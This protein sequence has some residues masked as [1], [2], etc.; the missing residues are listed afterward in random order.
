[1]WVSWRASVGVSSISEIR[2]GLE[3]SQA[4]RPPGA[5]VS[6][7]SRSSASVFQAAQPGHFPSHFGD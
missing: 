3:L 7:A 6:R 1:M 5:G 2:L 4:A